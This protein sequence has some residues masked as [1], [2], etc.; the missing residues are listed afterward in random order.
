MTQTPGIKS[1]MLS[2]IEEEAKRI[3]VQKDVD[4]LV[5]GAG[6]AGIAAAIAAARSGAS[7]CLIEFQGCLGGVWT[8]GLLCN[9]LDARNKPGLIAE[10]RRR[11]REQQA[12]A[13]HFDLY[14]AEVM[15]LLLEEMCAEAKVEIRLHARLCGAVTHERKIQHAIFEGKEGRFAIGAK[16]FI[17]TTGDG[18]LGAFAGCGFEIGREGD[19]ATQPMTLMALVGH[20]P[21]E[22]MSGRLNPDQTAC[23]PKDELFR[24]LSKQGVSTSYTQPSLFP[25]PNGLCALVVNHEYEKSAM[26]SIDLTDATLSARREIHVTIRAMRQFSPAWKNLTLVATAAHIG[27][28]EGRRIHGQYCVSINDVMEGVRHP[29]AVTRVSFPVDIH[30]GGSYDSGGVVARPYDIPLRALI[31]RDVENLALA[32]RCISGDFLA[33]ASYRV[34][35]NSVATGEAA[36]VLSSVAVQVGKSLSN[37]RF[38]DVL[39]QLGRFRSA[40]AAL[41]RPP[42]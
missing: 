39:D 42:Q 31:A 30:R 16:C 20:V 25:L 19:K 18:D 33:H 14:D 21:T 29:D 13:E 32:G 34:T 6:P 2:E 17:D 27:V 10:I 26:S 22:V 9:I 38:A 15:K 3:P 4:V 11:L 37:T 24:L 41:A 23:L 5:C 40:D 1:A 35:G 8:S 28:R 12:V 7:T 36:G